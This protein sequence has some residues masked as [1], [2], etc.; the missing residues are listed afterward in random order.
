MHEVQGIY[1]L[2]VSTIY[3]LHQVLYCMYVVMYNLPTECRIA[4]TYV[5]VCVATDV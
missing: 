3:I 5:D 1:N 4:C 2:M